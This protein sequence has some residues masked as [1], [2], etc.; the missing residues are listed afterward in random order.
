MHTAAGHDCC[1][2][3]IQDHCSTLN[4]AASVLSPS[5]FLVV[6]DH[7]SSSLAS[8]SPVMGLLPAAGSQSGCCTTFSIITQISAWS[9]SMKPLPKSELLSLLLKAAPEQQPCKQQPGPGP[10]AGSWRPA[11]SAAA[12]RPPGPSAPSG[13][14]GPSQPLRQTAHSCPASRTA[15][16]AGNQRWAE[17]PTAR[18]F[19]MLTQAPSLIT[20]PAQPL[21]Q[22]A[23]SCPAS[24][25]APAAPE[26]SIGSASWSSLCLSPQHVQ[27][28]VLDENELK[29][30]ASAL[31]LL[32]CLH[33]AEHSAP[34]S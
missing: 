8:G 11:W 33:P 16:A 15:P 14:T 18:C 31:L 13:P 27:P 25:T 29:D 32:Q 21:R 26:I 22:T 30:D 2:T 12:G 4:P 20:G 5:V 1:C 17:A 23:H 34:G 9:S 24:C 3:S 10:A 28:I 19:C 7:L 6:H